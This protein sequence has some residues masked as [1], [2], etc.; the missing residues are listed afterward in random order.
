MIDLVLEVYIMTDIIKKDFDCFNV[1][2][3]EGNY[4]FFH[5]EIEDTEDF[6]KKLFY[7]FF[8]ENRLLQ[9]AENNFHLKFEKSDKN[10]A[11]LYKNLR[12]FIDEKFLLENFDY[13]VFDETIEK[14][15]KEEYIIENKVGKNFIRIDKFGKVGEYIFSTILANYFKFD[16]IIP[17]IKLTTNYNMS[18]FGIDTLFYSSENNILLFG[19]S[20]VS[21]SIQNGIELI[22]TSL[23]DYESQINNEFLL[24]LSNR[25]LNCNPKFLEKF[26]QHIDTCINFDEFKN[27]ANLEAI[28][29]P[30]FIAHSSESNDPEYY[31][32]ELIKIPKTKFCNL[33]TYYYSISLPIVNKDKMMVVFTAEMKIKED[34]YKDAR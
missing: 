11:T 8:D 19:E 23:K 21:K 26:K 24:T 7:Y 29:I 17:K 1:Y 14:I 13:E 3:T 9:Y 32:N 2:S 18:V 16:C 33:D 12:Y 30:I 28:G 22:K 10:Y 25:T 34:L 15:L 5:I 31:L 27:C 20:K 6:Y 4:S